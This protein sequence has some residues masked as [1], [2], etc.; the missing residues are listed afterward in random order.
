MVGDIKTEVLDTP[1]MEQVLTPELKAEV[2]SLVQAAMAQMRTQYEHP[3]KPDRNSPNSCNNPV[4]ELPETERQTLNNTIASLQDQLVATEQRARG[5]CTVLNNSRVR[6]DSQQGAYATQLRQLEQRILQLTEAEV[7]LKAT[8]TQFRNERDAAVRREQ[9]AVIAKDELQAQNVLISSQLSELHDQFALKVAQLN[10]TSYIRDQLEGRVVQLSNEN[11]H[12]RQCYAAIAASKLDP[13][14]PRTPNSGP[15]S[16]YFSVPQAATNRRNTAPNILQTSPNGVQYPGLSANEHRPVKR[17][18]VDSTASTST[19]GAH[20]RVSSSGSE[21]FTLR[22]VQHPRTIT[23]QPLPSPTK[24]FHV[25]SPLA[26]VYSTSPTASVH[27][28]SPSTFVHITTPS[29]AAPTSSL[30]G[31]VNTDG[32]TCFV[33]PRNPPPTVTL[34]PAPRPSRAPSPPSGSRSAAQPL[35]AER[36]P[37]KG[38]IP[39]FLQEFLLQLFPP[40]TAGHLE[41]KLCK[42]RPEGVASVPLLNSSEMS[43]LLAHAEKL[44]P[45]VI[46]LAKSKHIRVV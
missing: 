2:A 5:A 27:P 12:W 35:L 11:E 1:K 16:V 40:T 43:E 32:F 38:S 7:S 3:I 36:S 29:Q 24:S 31:P 14:Y 15:P 23:T 42:S 18:R 10:D 26:S 8:Y 17:P 4:P 25:A 37:L 21:T 19:D 46:S 9:E 13:N 28:V 34:V 30:S 6:Y 45:R 39:A 41:C 20:S 22:P 33:P 44:H